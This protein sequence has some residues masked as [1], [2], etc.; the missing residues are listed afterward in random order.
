MKGRVEQ[1]EEARL[2]VADFMDNIS[3]YGKHYPKGL[4]ARI[5]KDFRDIETEL[6]RDL[7]I[8]TPDETEVDVMREPTEVTTRRLMVMG[9][10]MAPKRTAET[11]AILQRVKEIEPARDTRQ[12]R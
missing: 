4:V 3:D 8:K 12:Y 5:M 9:Q 1:Y 11:R 6:T 7:V 10:R 2:M